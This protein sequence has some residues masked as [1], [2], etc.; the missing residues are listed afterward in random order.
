MCGA[1]MIFLFVSLVS[2]LVH[3]LCLF[4]HI[5]SLISLVS[6]ILVCMNIAVLL[7]M[8]LHCLL[9]LCGH[10]V[11]L[12]LCLIYSNSASG[13]SASRH[14]SNQYSAVD[15]IFCGNHLVQIDHL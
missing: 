7:V 10:K 6:L 11:V 3:T 5:H 8:V 13:M 9:L 15:Y 1:V 4:H 14:Q 2:Q 12:N